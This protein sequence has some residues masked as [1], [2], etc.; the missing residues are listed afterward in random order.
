MPNYMLLFYAAE[1]ADDP[2]HVAKGVGA[3]VTV[4]RGVG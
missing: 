1:A 4:L 2:G 3:H